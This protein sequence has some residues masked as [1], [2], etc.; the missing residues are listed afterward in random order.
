M[1]ENQVNWGDIV[2]GTDNC[3]S[4]VVAW[5]NLHGNYERREWQYARAQMPWGAIRPEL[6]PSMSRQDVEYI[7]GKLVEGQ[8]QSAAPQAANAYGQMQNCISHAVLCNSGNRG[9]CGA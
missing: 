9:F 7:N 3:R 4:L 5:I 2:P 1:N 6:L 8:L